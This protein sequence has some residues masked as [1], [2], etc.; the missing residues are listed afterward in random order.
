MN[1]GIWHWSTKAFNGG[2]VRTQA[3]G[4]TETA[5]AYTS[6]ALV[7]LG[8]R[9]SVFCNT[10][11]S[12]EVRG[13]R[14]LPADGF[15]VGAGREAFDAFGIV[16][17][18]A[19]LTVPI[20]T[21]AL[22]YWTHD[23]LEQ[24]FLHGM[25]RFYE[26]SGEAK[27]KL[28]GCLSLGEVMPWIDAVIAVSRFQGEAI[29]RRFAVP[30]GKVAVIGNGLP[31]DFFDTPADPDHRRPVLLY[32]LPPDRGLEALLD[33]F[34][35]IRRER[36]DAELHL[37]S[38]STLYGAEAEED[39]RTYGRLYDRARRTPGVRH[40]DPVDRAALARAMAGARVYPYPATVEETFSISI[41]EAQASGMVPVSTPLGAIPERITDG[42]DG[43]LVEGAPGQISFQRRFA[44]R[45]VSLLADDT[46]YRSMAG[47]ALARARSEAYQYRSV[48]RRLLDAIEPLIHAGDETVRRFDLGAVPAPY[49]PRLAEGDKQW[50][51]TLSS[52]DLAALA[53]KFI[54]LLH[55]V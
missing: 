35:G 34:P 22:F 9:V 8:H 40:F 12:V 47:A 43:F 28:V 5:V 26:G 24:P 11:G 32:S 33:L 41:L 3:F 20:R 1:I 23:N 45:A 36:K 52:G 25:F 17:H 38:R 27:K 44:D 4:G 21:R 54:H 50:K 53:Q 31:P 55:L 48:A 49:R 13:V 30:A 51:G 10:P 46:L 42:I 6:E 7:E 2:L 39:E 14:Y 19:A 18:L 15:R 29:S 37:Y 16:R